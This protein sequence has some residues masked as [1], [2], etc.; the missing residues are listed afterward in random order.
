MDGFKSSRS[1][2]SATFDH[3]VSANDV[4]TRL[5]GGMKVG[6]QIVNNG[7]T[8]LFL[9]EDHRLELMLQLHVECYVG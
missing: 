3:G 2:P 6:S 7:A 5:T 4:T 9:D 8:L 1:A